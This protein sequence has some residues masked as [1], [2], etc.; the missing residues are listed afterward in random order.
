MKLANVI[1]RLHRRMYDA[2]IS[3]GAVVIVT[4]DNT[5]TEYFNLLSEKFLMKTYLFTVF[6]PFIYFNKWSTNAI[7][8]L[9]INDEEIR[10][11]V[12]LVFRYLF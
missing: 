2:A 3:C 10:K 1:V 6:W 4:C 5:S 8:T 12:L 9:K 7:K 11:V